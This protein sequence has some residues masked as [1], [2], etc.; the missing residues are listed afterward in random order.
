NHRITLYNTGN[1]ASA[2]PEVPDQNGAP[3][4]EEGPD[5]AR[6]DL[7]ITHSLTIVGSDPMR[8]D[9]TWIGWKDTVPDTDKS[10]IFQIHGD[11]SE[12][13]VSVTLK[14][15]VLEGGYASSQPVSGTTWQLVRNG[16]A[17]A[18][19]ACCTLV[20]TSSEDGGGEGGAPDNTGDGEEGGPEITGLTLE[21]VV[22]LDNHADGSGGGI[23]SGAPLVLMQSAIS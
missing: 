18:N 5:A 20:D 16:G 8:P 6:G 10:R 15:L 19:G 3:A 2:N 7:D 11:T 17:I 9:A 22:L 4:L 21:R 13:G 1:D 12:A 14:N 23:Y